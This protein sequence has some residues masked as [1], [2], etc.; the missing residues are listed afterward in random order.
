D[1]GGVGA[2]RDRLPVELGLHRLELVRGAD[3]DGDRVL[4]RPADEPGVTVTLGRARL[5][6]DHDVRDLC[7]GAGADA[8]DALQQRSDLGRDRVLEHVAVLLT[9]DGLVT[10]RELDRRVLVAVAAR[11]AVDADRAGRRRVA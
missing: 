1:R 5:A 8:D 10:V 11:A 3:P 6:G 7:A 4:R 9:V 2:T